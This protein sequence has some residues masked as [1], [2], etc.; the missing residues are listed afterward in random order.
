[1]PDELAAELERAGAARVEVFRIDD[2]EAAVA[3]NPA[4]LVLASGDGA[5]GSAARA[6]G[7]AGIPLALLPAGTAND[8]A[9][10]IGLPVD[11]AAACRV[12]VAGTVTREMELG[13]MD[14]RP[15][16]NAASAGLAVAAN[17]RAAPLRHRIGRVAYAV[18]ALGAALR[19][20]PLP[21]RVTRDGREML[22]GRAWQVTVACSGRFGGGSQVETADPGDGL[23]DLAVLMAGPRLRLVAHAY[24]LRS[25]TLTSQR[26]V[27]HGRANTAEVEV[28]EGTP[29]N[30]DGEV[31]DHGPATFSAERAAFRVVTG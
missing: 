11:T 17:R 23:L 14:G 31:I 5:V 1:M 4:R 19:E 26:G 6:A 20:P 24:G 3:S 22:A 18:G 9:R 27:R 10:V 8:F 7:R 29:F 30:V 12:A 15:F 28:P 2:V 25:G 16:V 13:D 21:C